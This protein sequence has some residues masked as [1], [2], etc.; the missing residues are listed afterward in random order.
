MAEED[1]EK[2]QPERDKEEARQKLVPFQM[3][4]LQKVMSAGPN[5][6][7]RRMKLKLKNV[8]LDLDSMPRM[9]VGMCFAGSL[10]IIVHIFV[11]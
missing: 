3:H 7:Q 9:T 8:S 11:C 6:G 5:P 1:S 10:V 4:F 2:D